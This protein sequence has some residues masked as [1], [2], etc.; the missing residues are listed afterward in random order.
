[1]SAE[2]VRRFWLSALALAALSG[3]A[4]AAPFSFN[5]VSFAG[6]ANQ[7]FKNDGRPLFVRNLGNC[8]REGKNK[9]GYRCFSGELLEDMPAKKGRNFCKLDAIWYVPF[10]KTVQFRTASCQFRTDQQRAID[11][12]QKLLRQGLEQLENFSR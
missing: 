4:Q 6:F 5:P 8:M 11:Q 9:A 10:S 3:A 12:G 1:L 2:P 7:T